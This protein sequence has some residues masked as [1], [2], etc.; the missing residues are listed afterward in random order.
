MTRDAGVRVHAARADHHREPERCALYA[1][2]GGC[3]A[4]GDIFRFPELADAL[5]RL[6][7]EGPD[8]IYRGDVARAGSASGCAERG[9]MLSAGGLRRVRGRSSASRCGPHTA[10]GEVL[11]NAPPSSGGILIAYA[12]GAAR[13]RGGAAAADDADALA[14]LAEVMGETNRARDGDFHVRLHEDGLRRAVPVRRL[15]S[16]GGRSRGRRRGAGAARPRRASARP[17]TCRCWTPTATRLRHVL[18]RHRLGGA[19]ARDRHPPQQH[20][21]RG[22]PQPA[23]LPPHEPGT[24]VTSM[25]APTI[26]LRDG[27]IELALG[28][29]GLEPPALGD[30]PGDPLRRRR[31]HGRRGGRAARPHALRGRHPARRSPGS[32]TRRSTSSSGAATGCVRW[33]GL[34]LYFGGAQAARRDRAAG[35][36]SGAGDPRRR[37]GV[38]RS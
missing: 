33:K 32:R 25:M 20:A 6:A 38:R 4:E 16:G 22:G 28:S 26:V 19:A 24:R 13:A 3:C 23:R 34:N 30:P 5:E 27:E 12:L 36:L 17:R 11:T 29:A 18:E 8:W 37:G 31:R 2:E 10:A 15:S 35:A 7:P 21:R 14:L 9:G 1:P